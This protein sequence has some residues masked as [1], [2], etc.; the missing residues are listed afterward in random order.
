L[1]TNREISSARERNLK[2]ICE[3]MQISVVNPAKLL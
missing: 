1:H 3:N 2:T